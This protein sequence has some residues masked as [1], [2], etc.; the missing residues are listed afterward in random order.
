MT[1]RINIQLFRRSP[2]N[3]SDQN[4]LIYFNVA[5][6]MRFVRAFLP[7]NSHAEPKA[8][9]PGLFKRLYTGA[10]TF[11]SEMIEL[12][13][14]MNDLA[15]DS[16]EIL[17]DISSHSEKLNE[18]FCDRCDSCD[19][20]VQNHELEKTIDESLLLLEKALE[21]ISSIMEKTSEIKNMVLKE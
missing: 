5:Y 9:K 19:A 1:K 14:N 11:K 4:V 10:G 20:K 7:N 3:P 6:L 8:K 18:T 2:G 12:Q 13:Q 21:E 15:A 17:S 16:I